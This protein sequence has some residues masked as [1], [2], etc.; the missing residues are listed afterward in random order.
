[1]SKSS[2]WGRFGF[3]GI[4]KVSGWP[5]GSGSVC[6]GSGA[7][8][9]FADQPV[10]IWC[11]PDLSEVFG[12]SGDRG[13]LPTISAWVCDP[14]LKSWPDRRDRRIVRQTDPLPNFESTERPASFSAQNPHQRP[15]PSVDLFSAEATKGGMPVHHVSVDRTTAVCYPFKTYPL[16][17]VGVS[18]SF[19]NLLGKQE[20]LIAR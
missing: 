15:L 12:P 20:I 1:M 17:F 11:S 7:L 16:K 13:R 2:F 5:L 19:A 9:I 3:A 6:H 4:R 10:F 18:V 14:A 8:F